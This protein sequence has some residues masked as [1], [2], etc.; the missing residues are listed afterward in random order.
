MNQEQDDKSILEAIDKIAYEAIQ[1]VADVMPDERYLEYFQNKVAE[2]IA[3]AEFE[4]GEHD[5]TEDDTPYGD[6]AEEEDA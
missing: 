4:A 3:D 5:W 2:E 6:N 1:A